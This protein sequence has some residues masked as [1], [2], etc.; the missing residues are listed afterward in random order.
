MVIRRLRFLPR[1]EPDGTNVV[2]FAPEIALPFE[3]HWYV[4]EASGEPIPK[5]KPVPEAENV[6]ATVEPFSADGVNVAVP[7]RGTSRMVSDV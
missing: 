5:L 2:L 4:Y 6:L 7:L 1:Y 3:Y